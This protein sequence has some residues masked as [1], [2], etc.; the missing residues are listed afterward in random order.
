M[1][2]LPLMRGPGRDHQAQQYCFWTKLLAAGVAR[3]IM[4]NE[5]TASVSVARSDTHWSS[6]HAGC[7]ACVGQVM[8]GHSQRFTHLNSGVGL[9]HVWVCLEPSLHACCSPIA[10]GLLAILAALS[11][12]LVGILSA[13]L[14]N[15]PCISGTISPHH[16]HRSYLALQR[17][18]GAQSKLPQQ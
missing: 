1:P 17:V 10:V 12:G 3:R 2:G 11:I 9:T 15:S 6:T 7:C 8:E 4:P 13:G 16:R 18:W 5:A 14:H